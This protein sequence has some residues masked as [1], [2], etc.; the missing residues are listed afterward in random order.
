VGD[1]HGAVG[2]VDRLAA[3]AAGA[4]DVDAQVL[5]LDVD[6]DVPGF[7]QPRPVLLMS[8]ISICQARNSA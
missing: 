4:E 6:I 7:R 3:G 1:A 5:L 8:R 2:R